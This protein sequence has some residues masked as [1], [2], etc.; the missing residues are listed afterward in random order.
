MRLHHLVG[1]PLTRASQNRSP[2]G[3]LREGTGKG[4]GED[5]ALQRGKAV[6]TRPAARGWG[7]LCYLNEFSRFQTAYWFCRPTDVRIVKDNVSGS[8][9][10]PTVFRLFRVTDE[11]AEGLTDKQITH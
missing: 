10:F 5:P 7:A 1:G 4:S 3:T 6:T 8:S 2:A 9:S 11:D